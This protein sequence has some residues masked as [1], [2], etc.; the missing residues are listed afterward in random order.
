MNRPA[1]VATL[2][3]AT[4]LAACAPATSGGSA[5]PGTAANGEAVTVRVAELSTANALTLG[6]A[7]GHVDD[8]LGSAGARAEWLGPFTV[9]PVAYEA[10][11]AGRAD[12]GSTGASRLVTWAADDQD[13]VAFA[14]ETYSG[15]SQGVVAAPGVPA[16]GVADLRGRTV[17]VGPAPGGTGDY[18]LALALADAGLTGDDV[19]KVY[20]PDSDAAAAFAAGSIDA[21]STYD[22][23]FATASSTRGA[24][25]LARGDAMGSHNASV[26]VVRRAFAQEH[27]DAVRALYD[28]LVAQA[29]AVADDPAQVA[30]LYAA[31]GAP[32]EAVAVIR[33]FDVPAIVP[34]D[35]AGVARLQALARDYAELGFVAAEPDM[36]RVSLDVTASRP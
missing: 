33:T 25:V 6:R 20:L 16:A 10:L 24:V 3:A 13:L 35:D 9:P 26:H 23:F 1:L 7:S 21:W 19:E 8:A 2:V 15:D 30:D 32:D 27:P 34:V 28:G 5:G 22:Q 17:A 18:V 12:A 31:A 14:L 36:A 29:S 11:L 4:V